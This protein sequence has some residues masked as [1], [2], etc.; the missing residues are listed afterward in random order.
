MMTR[1]AIGG[2]RSIRDL[3]LELSPLT[4]V[5]GPNGS[6]KS[7]LYRALRLLADVAPSAAFALA[8]LDYASMAVVTVVVDGEFGDGS[9]FLVPPVEGLAIKAA[10]CSTNKWAWSRAAAGE[11]RVVVRASLG[12]A[13]EATLLQHDDARLVELAHADLQAIVPGLGHVI[14]SHVQRW[15]GAL[16]QYEVGH[17][18]LVERVERD[19]ADVAGLEVCG[20]AY[21]GVGIPAVIA[22]GRAAA[23]RLL[24][25]DPH[26]GT[27]AR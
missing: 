8:G 22:S 4:I 10:T 17:L 12:R 20:A 9:G 16:P 27:E 18:D 6:G 2:Y 11:G 25:D 5:T 7:S 14:D 13:G 23:S 19:I 26:R 21:R 24:S 1:L 3:T 15:G